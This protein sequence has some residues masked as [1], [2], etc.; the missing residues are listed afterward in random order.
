MPIGE[1][2]RQRRLQ[3]N[4]TQAQLARIIGVSTQAVSKWETK[5]GMPDNFLLV[6]LAEALGITTDQ[7]LR[8]TRCCRENSH[9]SVPRRKLSA[10]FWISD[11]N[12]SAAGSSRS[13][14]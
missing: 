1:V 14:A 12:P 11:Q 3:L 4:L 6:P 5:V 2:I 9:C 10:S 13:Q 7:L 8:S